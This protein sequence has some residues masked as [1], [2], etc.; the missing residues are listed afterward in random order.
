M[1]RTFRNLI[2]D[3]AAAFLF[4]G[5]MAT[6]YI[7]RFP[8]PPGTNKVLTLWGFTRHQWGGIHFWLSS[9]FLG[10]VFVHI[11]LHWQWLVTVIG[12]RFHLVATSRPSFFSRGLVIIVVFIS[13]FIL[14]AWATHRS[15]K[16]ITEP[17]VGVCPPEVFSPDENKQTL[18]RFESSNTSSGIEFWKDVYPLFEKKCLSCHGPR[19]Q[20]GHFRIEGREDFL[21][22][23][24]KEPLVVPGKSAESPLIEVLSG[25][26]KDMLMLERHKL[27]LEELSRIKLWIDTGAEWS[28]KPSSQP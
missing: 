19:K 18:Q 2:V 7:L 22:F 28:E 14:F 4:L 12:R 8:L 20:L 21:G 16:Q 10:I 6:G 11:V 26:R 3:L 17:I 1:N 27:P 25:A 24:N 23:D 15:V 13:S 5:M 9:C